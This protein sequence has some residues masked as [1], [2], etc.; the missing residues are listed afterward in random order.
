MAER[1]VLEAIFQNA[2]DMSLDHLKHQ[3]AFRQMEALA[4]AYEGWAQSDRTS[5]EYS[6]R[7]LGWA[8]SL[9]KLAAEVGTAWDPP[10]PPTVSI[11][12]FLGPVGAR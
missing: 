2:A 9:R 6:A 1:E 7:L 8:E 3:L 5:P 11:I 10:T 12:G 4:C